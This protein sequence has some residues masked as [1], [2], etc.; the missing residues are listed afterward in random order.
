VTADQASA[1]QAA[2]VEMYTGG[3][4]VEDVG[5]VLAALAD[6]TRRQLLDVLVDAGRASATTL[7]GRLPVSRQAV[8]KHL[9]VLETAGLVEGVRA[10][11]EVL[12]SARPDPLDAS[13]RWLADL[14]AAWD[15]RLNALKRAAEEG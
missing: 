4:A 14:S 15:R 2:S 13:A 12:Y 8:V 11:R 7:A 5:A 3:G 10:G 1:D 9:H 6:P